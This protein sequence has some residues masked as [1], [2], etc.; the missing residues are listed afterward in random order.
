[1][2]LAAVNLISELGSSAASSRCLPPIFHF[3]YKTLL[4]FVAPVSPRALPMDLV[5]PLRQPHSQVLPLSQRTDQFLRKN[6]SIGALKIPIPIVSSPESTELWTECEKLFLSCL[7]TGDDKGAFLC[8]EKL[9]ERFGASN[10]KI[11]G[12]RGLYQEA[13]AE[14]EAALRKILREYDDI[15]AEDPTNTVC[16]PTR[17]YSPIILR[18]ALLI[19][20]FL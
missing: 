15:L 3:Y 8:L 6:G 19:T 1:M 10:E 13:V 7:R 18:C 5:S 12:L 4:I 11:M 16:P 9:I 2:Y 20:R 17:L 14:D